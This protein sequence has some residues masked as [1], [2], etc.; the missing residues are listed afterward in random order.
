MNR[1]AEGLLVPSVHHLQ[2]YTSCLGQDGYPEQGSRGMPFSVAA[3][4][5][6]HC[7]RRRYAT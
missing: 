1:I 4:P 3:P 2:K 7:S 5:F 6:Q